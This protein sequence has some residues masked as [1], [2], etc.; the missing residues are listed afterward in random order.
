[1]ARHD[2]HKLVL[3]AGK[4]L[5]PVIDNL[6]ESLGAVVFSSLKAAWWRR[7]ICMKW[8][9]LAAPLLLWVIVV[10]LATLTR[11][12]KE[13]VF[14]GRPLSQ[15][16]DDGFEPSSV[17][18]RELGSKAVPYLFARLRREDPVYGSWQTYHD[19][20]AKLPRILQQILPKPKSGNF[21]E[22]KTYNAL[23]AIGPAAL[24]SLAGGLR[25]HNPAVRIASAW[26]LGSFLQV[27]TNL[28]WAV[29]PLIEALKDPNSLVRLRAAWAVSRMGAAGAAAVP[30]LAKLL[31]DSDQGTKPGDKV[32]VRAWAAC[33]LGK[34]G[35]QASPAVSQLNELLAD[36]DQYTQVQAA[37]ALW[38]IGCQ[39]NSTLPALIHLLGTVDEDSKRE[40]IDALGEMGP[41]ARTALPSLPQ[42]HAKFNDSRL[43]SLAR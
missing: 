11:G 13:P 34:I 43:S 4:P 33:A 42:V 25:D 29:P 2:Q 12:A 39:T 9:Y 14:E 22:V 32:L 35:P 15:W 40:V 10:P 21:D 27:R 41:Q 17:A 23:F 20:H 5:E 28:T 16:L 7:L 6:G 30:S 18:L 26:A 36:L 3:A 37:I 19:F 1:L 38:R 31:S 24:P 8:R